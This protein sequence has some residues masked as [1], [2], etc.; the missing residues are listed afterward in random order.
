MSSAAKQIGVSDPGPTRWR[1]VAIWWSAIGLIAS[2][3]LALL[4]FLPSMSPQPEALTMVCYTGPFP[5][6]ASAMFS[7][8]RWRGRDSF[9]AL[10]RILLPWVGPVV[11]LAYLCSATATGGPPG[12]PEIHHGLYYFNDHGCLIPTTLAQYR[13]GLRADQR[14]FASTSAIFYAVAFAVHR[15]IR[16]TRRTP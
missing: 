9:A 15:Y 6:F 4:S 2:L 10:V 13:D 12:Q 8:R 11:A 5:V 7:L 16:M 14:D 1:T 3:L